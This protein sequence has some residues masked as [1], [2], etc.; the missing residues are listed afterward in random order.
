MGCSSD[1]EGWQQNREGDDEQ[2]SECDEPCIRTAETSKKRDGSERDWT[3]ALLYYCLDATSAL[4]YLQMALINCHECSKQISSEA[5][6]CPHCGV[7]PKT[8][9]NTIAALVGLA[10]IAF[11]FGFYVF[12]PHGDKTYFEQSVHRQAEQDMAEISRQV[13]D[14]AERQYNIARN[15]GNEMDI[16]VQAMSVSAAFLQAKDDASYAKWKRI[17]KADCGRAGLQQ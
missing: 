8:K 16:C 9:K 3:G 2:L 6:K 14:D 7:V 15:H 17:E 4:P 13:A 5:E 11:V 10:G 1:A 12:K